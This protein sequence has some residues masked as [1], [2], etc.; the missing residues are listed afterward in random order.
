[1]TPGEGAEETRAAVAIVRAA[2]EAAGLPPE[3][4]VVQFA[5]VRADASA[6][7]V[8]RLRSVYGAAGATSVPLLPLDGEGRPE[9]GD[10][11]LRLAETIGAAR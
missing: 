2:R 3:S 10:G 8:R 9:S 7:E 4:A 6:D 11:I 1:M 5:G